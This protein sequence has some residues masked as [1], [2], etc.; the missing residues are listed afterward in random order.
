[1][2]NSFDSNRYE[3]LKA[4]GDLPSP[5]GVALA[6]I[7][8]TQQEDVSMAELARVIR[9]DP[10]FVGRLIKAANGIVAMT[11]R[12]VVSVHEALMVLGLPAVR[13]MALGFSLLSSYRRGAC[14]GFDYDAFWSSSLVAALAVQ[15]FAQRNRAGAPDELFS[16]GLL[17][18]IGSLALATL[19]PAEYAR[20]LAEVK[21]YPELRLVDLEHRAFAMTH[22]DLAAAM[23]ADWGVPKVLIEP[24][25]L[26][27]TPE[28]SGAVPGS[29]DFML[30]NTVVAGRLVAELCKAPEA[31][32]PAL[33]ARLIETGSKVDMS[34]GEIVSASD[35]VVSLW[36]DWVDT[37]DL[38]AGNPPVFAELVETG[39][40]G[41]QGRAFAA[42]VVSG[43]DPQVS[44]APAATEED[45]GDNQV[46]VLV[47]EDDPA[48]RPAVRS[49]RR[50]CLRGLR[51]GRRAQRTRNGARSP[52][53]HPAQRLGNAADGRH[54]A[55]PRTAR[56]PHRAQRLHPAAHRSGRG[57]ASDRGLRGGGG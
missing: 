11:R 32:R 37:L 26:H 43:V 42:A 53:A 18:D 48:I 41:V 34:A 29:R 40:A 45:A 21:R 52:A 9:S 22:T 35:H 1:M 13:T 2:T 28:R 12:P 20:V 5:R 15:V 16:V 14:H 27:E 51:G 7:R 36:R 55:D 30:L 19:Y 49:A 23:L 17:S 3:K 57:R 54:G 50:S 31:D 47:V 8:L 25:K 38:P 46:R 56:H 33:L 10:A 44:A 4:S 24:V 39:E 6:I